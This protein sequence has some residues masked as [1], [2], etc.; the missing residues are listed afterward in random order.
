MT[1]SVL[2]CWAGV[3]ITAPTDEQKRIW[4]GCENGD[5]RDRLIRFCKIAS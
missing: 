1:T 3:A 4:A 5:D 2:G